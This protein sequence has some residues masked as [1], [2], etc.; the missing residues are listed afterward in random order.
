MKYAIVTGSTRGIGKSIGEKLLSEGCFVIFNYSN[1]DH[2]AKKLDNELKEHHEGKYSIIKADLSNYSGLEIFI[3][4]CKEINKSWDYLILNTAITDRSN[5]KNVTYDN[6]DKVINTN[7]NVPFF[8]VQSLSE[9]INTNGR[10]I[11][12]SS[13]MGQHPHSMSISYGVSKAAISFLTKSLV[14]HF[15]TKSITVNAI[16]PGFVDTS[17]Q[18]EKDPSHKKRVTDKIALN[19]FALPEEIADFTYSVIKNDYINGSVLNID[20]GYDY[21]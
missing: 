16:C 13:I 2:E 19:R 7:L 6:W 17:W 1:D 21:K 14:K 4:K 15:T 10:I 5:F 8:V 11:F 20:G 12:I 9:K 18:L 3:N